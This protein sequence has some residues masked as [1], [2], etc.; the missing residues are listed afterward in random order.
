MTLD[1]IRN[2][3]D[4]LEERSLLVILITMER[5]VLMMTMLLL[6]MVERIV[7]MRMQS[8]LP[9]DLTN[10]VVRVRGGGKKCL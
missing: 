3:C 2:S 10:L 6:M 4:V 5:V 1:S 8:F 7:L 9:L